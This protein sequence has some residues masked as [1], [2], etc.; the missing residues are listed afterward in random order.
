MV[1]CWWINENWK[2]IEPTLTQINPALLSREVPI[3]LSSQGA[4]FC[5]A[6]AITLDS[7]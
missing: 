4:L 3:T 6:S 1:E 2:E 7:A 5:Q